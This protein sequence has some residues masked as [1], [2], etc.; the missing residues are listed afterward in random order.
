VADSCREFAGRAEEQAH[1]L[2]FE[3]RKQFN[4]SAYVNY[5]EF[6]FTESVEGKTIDRYTGGRPK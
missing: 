3:L 1:E 5:K 4:L 2:V 6:D